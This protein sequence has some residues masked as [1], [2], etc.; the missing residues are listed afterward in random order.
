MAEEA[1]QTSADSTVEENLCRDSGYA[2][3]NGIA[4]S[5][6]SKTAFVATRPGDMTIFDTTSEPPVAVAS[7]NHGGVHAVAFSAD[8]KTVLTGGTNDN[9][10]RLWDAKTGAPIGPPLLNKDWVFAVALTPDGKMALT[11]I[12]DGTVTW[13]D[14]ATGNRVKDVVTKVSS[15]M[16][17]AFSADTKSILVGH[18]DNTARLWDT[19][20]GQPLGPYLQHKFPVLSVALSPD[21]Q[22]MMTASGNAAQLWNVATGQPLGAPLMHDDLVKAVAFS[23]DGNTAITASDDGTARFWDLTDKIPDD[24]DRVATWVKVLT[25]IEL[26][27][28]GQVQSLDNKTWRQERERLMQTGGTLISENQPRLDPILFGPNPTSRANALIDQ[29]RWPEAEAA[30]SDLLAARPDFASFWLARG[31]FYASRAQAEKAEADFARAFILGNGDSVLRDAIVGSDHLFERIL[32]EDPESAA[33]LW[34]LRGASFANQNRWQAAF[35]AYE[36]AAFLEPD[37]R[38]AW[39]RALLSSAYV[40]SDATTIRLYAHGLSRFCKTISAHEANEVAWWLSIPSV[41]VADRQTPVHLAEFACAKAPGSA[42]C[43]NTLGLVLYRSARYEEAIQ[44]IEQGVALKGGVLDPED[45]Y[46]LALAHF[47]LGRREE[48]IRWLHHKA[49]KRSMQLFSDL[50][51]RIL[52]QEAEAVVLYDP[53]FPADPFAP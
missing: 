46:I 7:I 41:D 44:K 11:G 12:G 45:A 4:F 29:K 51:Q 34:R 52:R 37:N 20:T 47:R 42:S 43:L 16:S 39:I 35:L 10:S 48:A 9:T 38:A 22:S 8:G 21:G 28:Y 2:S 5:P 3:L 1:P 32:A 23:A 26:D 18:A 36:R 19:S 27:Q 14:Q 53:V 13:W 15:I 40:R 33:S 17:M 49:A 30:F 50:A 6:D 24:L 31:Q 25:G